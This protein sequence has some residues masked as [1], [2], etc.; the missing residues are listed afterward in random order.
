MNDDD[1]CYDPRDLYVHSHNQTYDEH[2]GAGRGRRTSIPVIATIVVLFII[3]NMVQCWWEQTGGKRWEERQARIER[4]KTRVANNDV[5]CKA[6][7]GD[8]FTISKWAY[9]KDLRTELVKQNPSLKCDIGMELVLEHPDRRDFNPK[10]GTTDRVDMLECRLSVD[11]LLVMMMPKG[12]KQPKL[13]GML[14]APA[15]TAASAASTL[16]G[17]GAA[18][19]PPPPPTAADQGVAYQRLVLGATDGAATFADRL[20]E[21]EV[22]SVL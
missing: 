20:G 7:S 12:T 15:A 10:S 9:V 8:E 4:W 1:F 13:D 18:P 22:E 21:L 14:A 3:L 16:P 6:I 11:N 17:G 2:C 19:P 5:Q